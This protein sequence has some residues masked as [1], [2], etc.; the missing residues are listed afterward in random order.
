[1][2]LLSPAPGFPTIHHLPL[3][4][5]ESFIEERRPIFQQTISSRKPVIGGKECL[6]TSGSTAN[7]GIGIGEGTSWGY[8]FAW[9]K[10]F[11]AEIGDTCDRNR[12]R[13][14]ITVLPNI[15]N[16]RCHDSPKSIRVELGSGGGDQGTTADFM[17][18]KEFSIRTKKFFLRLRVRVPL[19]GCAARWWPSAEINWDS[20]S[21]GALPNQRHGYVQ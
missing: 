2:T 4:A 13:Q 11:I 9:L 3:L 7:V 12:G 21:L 6:R 10:V 8:I 1:M 18:R 5:E 19:V 15:L 17:N 16:G 20:L 14:M